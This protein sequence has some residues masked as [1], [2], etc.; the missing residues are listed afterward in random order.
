MTLTDEQKA[1]VTAWVRD[2]AGLSEIQKRLRT[3]LGLAMTYMD[4]RLLVIDLDLTLREEAPPAPKPKPKP[5]EPDPDVPA[6]GV[7][8]EVDRLMKPGA[9]VSGSVVFSDGRH[10][11]WALDQMGRLA[12]DAGDREYRPSEDD[13]VDF[14]E[15]LRAA[16]R[17]QG[18]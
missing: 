7:R 4:V 13:M 9:L 5:D 3:E 12:L 6:S 8:V 14:Q 11:T 1:A 18:F 16:L 10:A 17:K 2:G 15:S